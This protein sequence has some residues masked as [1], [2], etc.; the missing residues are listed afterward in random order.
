MQRTLQL[1]GRGYAYLAAWCIAA[2]AWEHHGLCKVCCSAGDGSAVRCGSGTA[3]WLID[4]LP[5]V[6]LLACTDENRSDSDSESLPTSGCQ[7]MN[8]N[9]QAVNAQPNRA[10]NTLHFHVLRV[11][12]VGAL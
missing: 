4:W 9:A 2:N 6:I 1:Q 11:R 8:V 12:T 5:I 10:D 3:S 7:A